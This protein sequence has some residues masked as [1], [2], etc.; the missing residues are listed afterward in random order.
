[1]NAFMQQWHKTDFSFFILNITTSAN[2]D[3]AHIYAIVEWAFSLFAFK[4]N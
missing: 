3:H 1:M 2:Q 4:K